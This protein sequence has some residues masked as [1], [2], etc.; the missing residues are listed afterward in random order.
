MEIWKDIEFYGGYYQVSNLGRVKSLRREIICRDGKVK[1]LKGRI[2][3]LKAKCNSGYVRVSLIKD[4]EVEKKL[5]H[6]LVATTFIQT[7]D[8]TLPVN[9]KNFDKSDNRAENLEFTTTKENNQHF[10]QSER[11]NLYGVGSHFC[12]YEEDEVLLIS[13]LARCGYA[14]ET[15]RKITKTKM[16]NGT[17]QNICYGRGWVRLTNIKTTDFHVRYRHQTQDLSF[18]EIFRIF[19]CLYYSGK[20]SKSFYKYFGLTVNKINNL[21]MSDVLITAWE[22]IRGIKSNF[23]L[24]CKCLNKL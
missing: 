2:L 21:R 5:V 9:H 22:E 7:E 1:T 12:K 19:D 4:G 13:N 14:P 18:G 6:R 16:T 8:S 3:S 10:T 23:K 15:I 11:F 20:K 24:E 17:V